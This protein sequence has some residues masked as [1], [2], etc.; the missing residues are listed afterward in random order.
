LSED[1]KLVAVDPSLTASGWV[2]F[3]LASEKPLVA[4]CIKAGPPSLP[5]ANR[6]KTFQLEVQSLI[7]KF[8]LGE[9]DFLITEGPAPLVKNPDSATKVE[10]VRGI[11]E[12]IA[13]ARGLEV[14]GRVN[15]RSVHTELLAFTGAQ[16]ERKFV[17]ES[18]RKV[19]SNLM[20]AE[21]AS[22]SGE[23]FNSVAQ[24]I[25]DAALVG[26]YAISR[27]KRAKASKLPVVEMFRPKKASGRASGREGQGRTRAAR[28]SEADLKKRV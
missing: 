14:P 6:L 26:V 27:I 7:V 22:A 12:T 15:P 9:G 28:W 10:Q 17:K 18:A 19:A 23:D 1:R 13:R 4:G 25:I 24:D 5:L 16:K 3:S 21:L 20:G 11:F 8:D 2:I